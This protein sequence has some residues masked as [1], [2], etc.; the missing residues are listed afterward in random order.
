MRCMWCWSG[1]LMNTR[2]P[3]LEARFSYRF[4]RPVGISAGSHCRLSR[5]HRQW[6]S[7]SRGGGR[8]VTTPLL[9]WQVGEEC[10]RN[11]LRPDQAR[12]GPGSSALQLRFG[13]H[14][15]PSLPGLHLHCISQDLDSD[16]LSNKKHYNSFATEFFVDVD[17][18]IRCAGASDPLTLPPRAKCIWGS[19]AVGADLRRDAWV[20]AMDL[21]GPL[22]ATACPAPLPCRHLEDKGSFDQPD[23][24]AAE[25]LL[26][27]DLCCLHCGLKLPTIPRLKEHLL[28][29]I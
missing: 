15:K 24:T 25:A 18:V 9:S 6:C 1:Y 28:L 21:S 22:G 2:S 5:G 3:P 14:A 7:G 4:R 12:S 10:A 29:H 23:P 17:I 16:R 8:G 27:Q 11:H 19:V 20:G 13:F 26:R